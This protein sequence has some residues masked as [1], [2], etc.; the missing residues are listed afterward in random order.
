M[1]AGRLD[2]WQGTGDLSVTVYN[3][4]LEFARKDDDLH[5]VVVKDSGPVFAAREGTLNWRLESETR[6]RTPPLGASSG[7]RVSFQPSVAGNF[8]LIA[9]SDGS[10]VV[11]RL[12]VVEVTFEGPEPPCAALAEASGMSLEAVFLLEGGGRDRRLGTSSIVLGNVGNLMADTLEVHYPPAGRAR[13]LPGGTPPLLD[14]SREVLS[15]GGAEVFR[16]ASRMEV[17][18]GPAPGLR[19]RLTSS[20]NPDFR[21]ADPHPVTVKPARSVTGANHFREFVVAYSL[22]FP[23]IYTALYRADWIATPNAPGR[24]LIVPATPVSPGQGP[25]CSGPKFVPI[26]DYLP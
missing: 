23:Q 9:S 10:Q 12:S 22:S 11:A 13:E 25:V 5:I 7:T 1:A 14:T 21:W 17:V 6:G 18:P 4:S 15:L 3:R 26:M 16:A 24:A 20:D 2:L 19:L 8:R